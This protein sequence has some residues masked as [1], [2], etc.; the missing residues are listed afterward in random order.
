MFGQLLEALNQ[1]EI[2]LGAAK[3]RGLG[4]FKL[5][6]KSIEEHSLY[7]MNAILG[8]IEKKPGKSYSVQELNG[9]A[10]AGQARLVTIRIEWQPKSALMVKA[11]YEGIGV[12]MLPLTSS[13]GEDQVSLVLPGSSIKGAFRAQAERILRTLLDLKAPRDPNDR[14][15]FNNQLQL[16]GVDKKAT[17]ATKLIGELFGAKKEPDDSKW[18]KST[19][20]QGALSIDDCY[21]R[22][23]FLM[24]AI[25][26]AKVETGKVYDDRSYYENGDKQGEHTL[27]QALKNVEGDKDDR[28]ST[29]N[30]QISH[31]VAI[32]RWTGGASEGALFSVLQPTQRIR[33]DNICMALDLSRLKKADGKPDEVGQRRCLMLLLLVLRDFAENRLPLGFATNRGMGEVEV[34]HIEGLEMIPKLIGLGTETFGIEISNGRLSFQGDAVKRAL[35]GAWI[36]V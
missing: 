23:E 20:G 2:R 22:R 9:T 36:H 17:E 30:F 6:A 4:K 24:N 14:Q 25:D 28:S 32:D 3:T 15:N 33:W 7:G 34:L 8:L 18:E 29:R 31:H 10:T 19:L 12:D 16:L 11:G 1:G 21:A 27:W 26:W 13:Y 35:E 5:K